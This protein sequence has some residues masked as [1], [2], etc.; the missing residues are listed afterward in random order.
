[1]IRHLSLASTG[2]R[3]TRDKLTHMQTDTQTFKEKEL[4]HHLLK[5]LPYMLIPFTWYISNKNHAY[6]CMTSHGLFPFPTASQQ[7]SRCLSSKI[8]TP[9]SGKDTSKLPCEASVIH[10]FTWS[11]YKYCPVHLRSQPTISF[12]GH[13]LKRYQ[14]SNTSLKHLSSML[15]RPLEWVGPFL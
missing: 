4:Q 15:T 1:M 7:F 10:G 13:N 11:D 14:I 9:F 12:V 2:T 6:V 8:R 5:M 3:H